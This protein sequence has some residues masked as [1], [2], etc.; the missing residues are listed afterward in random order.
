MTD[1]RGIE[2]ARLA[3]VEAREELWM[4]TPKLAPIEAVLALAHKALTTSGVTRGW[5]LA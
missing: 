2:V 4:P 1:D 5:S 3:I